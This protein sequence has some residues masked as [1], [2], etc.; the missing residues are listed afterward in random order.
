MEARIKKILE[1]LLKDEEFLATLESEEDPE[2]DSEEEDHSSKKKAP[3]SPIKVKKVKMSKKMEI[4]ESSKSGDDW[5]MRFS[6]EVS[7][8]K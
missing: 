6:D 7:Q 8:G 1:K 3:H 5:S 4:G 2:Q